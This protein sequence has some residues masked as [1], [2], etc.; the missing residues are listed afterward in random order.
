MSE[1]CGDHVIETSTTGIA[2][3]EELGYVVQEALEN[4]EKD[5]VFLALKA[6]PVSAM[7]AEGR[8][9]EILEEALQNEQEKS[10]QMMAAEL[11]DAHVAN[12]QSR[13]EIDAANTRLKSV[14][15]LYLL[16]SHHIHVLILMLWFFGI[17]RRWSK[18]SQGLKKN[19]KWPMTVFVPNKIVSMN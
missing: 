16:F 1:D 8:L 5:E 6:D 13:G 9:R 10:I 3:R 7:F 18:S 2:V 19:G 17:T 12:D 14:R 11:R 15:H 4:A